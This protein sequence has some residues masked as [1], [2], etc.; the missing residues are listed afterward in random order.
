MRV[1][2]IVVFG[3]M[4]FVRAVRLAHLSSAYIDVVQR[5]RNVKKCH[6]SAE[7]TGTQTPK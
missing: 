4:G 1:E 7:T 5:R 6:G 2:P 3:A